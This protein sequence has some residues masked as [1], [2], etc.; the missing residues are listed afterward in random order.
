MDYDII[1]VG[2]S[3]FGLCATYELAKSGFKVCLFEKS[4]IGECT[5]STGIIFN[6]ALKD[7]KLPDRLIENKIDGISLYAPSM[8]NVVIDLRKARFYNTNTLEFLKWL[9]ER[10]LSAGAEIFE[11][12]FCRK[13]KLWKDMAVCEEKSCNIIIF[14]H[15][16][17]KFPGIPLPRQNLYIGFEHIADIGFSNSNYWRMYFDNKISPGYFSWINPTYRQKCHIGLAR[18]TKNKGSISNAFSSFCKKA[19]IKIKKIYETRC[20]I[21]PLSGPIEKPYG[22]RYLFIGDAAGQIGA[23]SA[24][25]IQYAPRVAKIL[26][27]SVPNFIDNPTDKNIMLYKTQLYK[28]I[29]RN[30]KEELLLRKLYNMLDTNV[31]L[32]RFV[33]ILDE[34]DHKKID[35][36]L[37]RLSNMKKLDIHRLFPGIVARFPKL[38]FNL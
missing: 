26:S 25:G 24:G 34:I 36:F 14:A 19:G 13:I 11:R 22:Y 3:F 17:M 16:P 1:I 15:G 38:L 21:V 18:N 35:E 7:L 33:E 32:E 5:K 10:A 28:E 37:Y 4:K 20:G 31:K 9:K 6:Y 23:M 27:K 30:L 29:G 12:K 2:G 8:K